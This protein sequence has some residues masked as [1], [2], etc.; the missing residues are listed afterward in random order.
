MDTFYTDVIFVVHNYLDDR[1][2]VVKPGPMRGGSASTLVWGPERQE[3]AHESLKSPIA[4][5]TEVGFF[6]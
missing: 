6:L 5:I 1:Q 2:Y 4:L 3:G